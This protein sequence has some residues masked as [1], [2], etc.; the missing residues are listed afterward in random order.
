MVSSWSGVFGDT[1]LALIGMVHLDALPG[2]P[3]WD[4]DME[5]VIAHA[6]EDVAILEEMG[7]DALMVENLND[8]PFFR[9]EVGYE[10]IA[11][12]AV[13]G[14]E[15]RKAASVEIGFQVLRNVARGSV[16][17]AA[18]AG[19]RFVR[20]NVHTDA[21]LTDQGIVQA[22][23]A[24]IARYR[25]LLDADVLFFCDLYT[26]HA[27]PLAERPIDVVAQDS[28]LRGKASAL[29]LSG[30]DSASP[31]TVD[32]VTT[33][34]EAVPEAKLILGSG[35]P[36][37]FTTELLSEVDGAIIPSPRRYP[38]PCWTDESD[39]MPEAREA[40]NA[41]IKRVSEVSGR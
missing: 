14:R 37:S 9:D 20:I 6:L 31:P 28:V 12:M 11:A 39:P 30:V 38:T 4:G 34:R 22:V 36:H 33:V 24:D 35:T 40:A 27:A 41:W 19:G 3:D 26:K 15:V 13:V 29:I 2:S 32:E 17:L 25:R 18:A 1:P 10:T 16:A 8:A 23:S 5:S 7:C 21:M